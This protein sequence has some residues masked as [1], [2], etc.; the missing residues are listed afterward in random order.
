[1]AK[2]KVVPKKA[3][4]AKLVRKAAKPSKKV[5]SRA[6][7][8]AGKIVIKKVAKPVSTRPKATK[9]PVGASRKA[10]VGKVSTP[11]TT[12]PQ[13]VAKPEPEVSLGRPLVTQEEKLYMLFHNDYHAR[14][15]FEFLRVDTVKELEQYTPQQ[16]IHLLSKPIRTTVDRIRLRLAEL[17]RSLR[18]DESFAAAHNTK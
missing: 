17:K 12:G 16:I 4:P 1:M 2:K 13:L 11:S 15:V 14:Q 7:P 3:A 9:V 18:E 10:P 6:K 8:T 5:A